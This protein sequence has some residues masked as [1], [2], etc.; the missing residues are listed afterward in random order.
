MRGPLDDFGCR[1]VHICFDFLNI[2]LYTPQ[3]YVWPKKI[4]F[5]FWNKDFSLRAIQTAETRRAPDLVLKMSVHVPPEY[6]TKYDV[7]Q[8]K[9]DNLQ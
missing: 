4:D 7:V 9:R 8:D 3:R 2:S 1:P 5:G 6:R